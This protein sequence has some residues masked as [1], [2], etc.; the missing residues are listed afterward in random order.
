MVKV[1]VVVGVV[2][3]NSQFAYFQRIKKALLNRSK[4]IQSSSKDLQFQNSVPKTSNTQ[5]THRARSINSMIFQAYVYWYTPISEIPFIS[6]SITS[7]RFVWPK[8][9]FTR[10]QFL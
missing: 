4:Q 10:L 8:E 2:Q 9:S 6:I 7:Y 1:C 3:G 5:A